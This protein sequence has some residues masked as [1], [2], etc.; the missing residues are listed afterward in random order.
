MKNKKLFGAA[1][2][3]TGTIIGA[4]ILGLPYVFSKSGFLLGLFWILFLGVVMIFTYLYIAEL[5]LR[6]KGKHQLPGLAKKYLGDRWEYFTLIAMLFGIYASLLAYLIG[7]GESLSQL[8]MGGT[9]FSVYFT[10]GFWLLLTLLLEGGLERLKTVETWGVVAIIVIVIGMFFYFMPR[11]DLENVVTMDLPNF[12]VPFGVTLFALLGFSSLPEIREELRGSEKYLLPAIILGVIIPIV[13]YFLFAFTF[14][15]V[16]GKEISEIAT[17]S[18]GGA[19]MILL[20]IFTMLTSYFVLSYSVRDVCRLDL[21]LSK[22]ETFFWSSLFPLILFF[23]VYL[24]KINSFILILGVGGVVSG[25][26]TA[27]MGIVMNF[28]AK[29]KGERKPEFSVYINKIIVI[30]LSLIFIGGI[31]VEIYNQLF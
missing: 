12:F 30:I 23:V 25:G 27:I 28:I 18:F 10:I 11:Y 5:S 24:I 3:L 14:I 22:R 2:T 17:L 31:F 8:F 1:F 26:V 19:P 15:G 7:E 6:T 21:K 20:G 13:L 29:K 4:G 16:M 9:E